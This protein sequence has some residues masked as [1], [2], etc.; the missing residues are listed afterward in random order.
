MVRVDASH[1]ACSNVKVKSMEELLPIETT[2]ANTRHLKQREMAFKD[3]RH[4]RQRFRVRTMGAW[5]CNKKH[6][7]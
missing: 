4:M 6:K 7:N 1:R 2:L 3:I 5:R